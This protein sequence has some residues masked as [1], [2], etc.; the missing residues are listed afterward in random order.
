MYELQPPPSNKNPGYTTD[1][2]YNNNINEIFTKFI[3]I[4]TKIIIY[5]Y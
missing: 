2:I 1:I 3:L 5:L 4:L